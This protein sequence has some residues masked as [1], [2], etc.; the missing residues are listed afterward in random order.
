ML[1]ILRLVCNVFFG[2]GHT[3]PG[4]IFRGKSRREVHGIPRKRRPH[5]EIAEIAEPAEKGRKEVF[6]ELWTFFRTGVRHPGSCA[7]AL[8]GR[9]HAEVAELAEEG[10]TGIKI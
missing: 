8:E 10:K 7:K 6:S 1:K 3:C 5:A 2:E 9:P 4:F